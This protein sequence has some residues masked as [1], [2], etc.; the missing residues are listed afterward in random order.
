MI[1][2]KL[3]VWKTKNAGQEE[4]APEKE[5]VEEENSFKSKAQNFNF[6]K[7]PQKPKV[8]HISYKRKIYDKRRTHDKIPKTDQTGEGDSIIC[9]G[10]GE[11]EEAAPVA[12]NEETNSEGAATVEP[13]GDGPAAEAE[14]VKRKSKDTESDATTEKVA[15]LK[16]FAAE[17][18]FDFTPSEHANED[19]AAEGA[20]AETVDRKSKDTASTNEDVAAEA[21]TVDRKSEDTAPTNEDVAAEAE[22]VDRKSEDTASTNEDEELQYLVELLKVNFCTACTACRS[23]YYI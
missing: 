22:T 18:V 1:L 7:K 17:I 4:I 2:L 11:T 13:V 15:K 9:D 20:E 6:R 16:E 8:R 10:L 19:V 23:V 21:E 14:A 12:A 5:V 3:I